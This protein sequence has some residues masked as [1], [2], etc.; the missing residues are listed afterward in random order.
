VV[1]DA[2]VRRATLEVLRAVERDRAH[3]SDAL[4]RTFRRTTLPAEERRRVASLARDV[5]RHRRRLDFVLEHRETTAPRGSEADEARLRLLEQGEDE[6]ARRAIASIADPIE[7]LATAHSL[8]SWFARTLAEDRGYK[9]AERLAEA[10]NQPPPTTLRVN[11]LVLT[12][13]ELVERL[14][15]EGV[16]ARLLPLAPDA[17]MV[18]RPIEVSELAAYGEGLFEIQ[19]A[20]SQLVSVLVA[21][22]PKGLVVDACAGAGGKTIHLATLLRG[23]GRVVASDLLDA[24]KKLDVLGLRARRAG[25]HNI[26]VH[27]SPSAAAGPLAPELQALFGRAD[28]VLV[29]APCSG[30]GVLRRNPDAK[31][32]LVEA[33]QP[34]LRALQLEILERFAPLVAAGGRLIYATCSLLRSENQDQVS[35][36]LERNAAF[37]PVSAKEI[38]GTQRALE[39]GDGAVLSVDPAHSAAPGPDGFFAAVLRRRRGFSSSEPRPG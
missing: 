33:D 7:R 25:L 10:L 18:E 20:G 29:D 1:N 28:R 2:A 35:A 9:A 16:D 21:P 34:R 19:D 23:R 36:F 31:W 14:V 8:P 39:I 30:S 4:R 12:A 24:T 32:R 5:L 17:V 26:A 22:P 38:L 3:A 6:Q 13:S 27:P 37:E 11:R 15:R